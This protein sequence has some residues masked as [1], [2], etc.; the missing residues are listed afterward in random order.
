MYIY[1]F[2][3]IYINLKTYTGSN[4]VL[5]IGQKAWDK[6]NVTQIYSLVSPWGWG[7]FCDIPELRNCASV[8]AK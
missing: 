6:N 7:N 2:G 5:F 1:F 3:I 8:S 4:G